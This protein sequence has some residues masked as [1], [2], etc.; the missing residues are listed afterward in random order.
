MALNQQLSAQLQQLVGFSS[1]QPQAIALAGPDG[2]HVTIEVTAVD[3]M[4]CSLSEIRLDV[5]KLQNDSF[6]ALKTW[7]AALCGRV[8]YLLEGIGPLEFD[9]DQQQVLIRSNP[10]STQGDAHGF[11]E[12][13]LQTQADGQ[14]TLRR[15]RSEKGVPGRDQVDIQLTHEV[16][17][18]LLD[19]LV[20]T[21]PADA[22]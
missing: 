15:Y 17:G 20:D 5:P 18:K 19:D 12:I 14:F 9:V 16:L 8:T 3:S 10:P 2:I 21:I 22:S 6:E 11:Y 13:V 1:T 7:A 4:S